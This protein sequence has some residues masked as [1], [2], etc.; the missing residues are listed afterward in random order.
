MT[1]TTRYTIITAIVLASMFIGAVAVGAF[2][3]LTEREQQLVRYGEL[4]QAMNQLHDEN[5]MYR[6][7][8]RANGGKWQELREEKEAIERK[9]FQ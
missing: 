1:N 5:N 9:L 2:S 4:A 3:G 6:E 8:I 7:I